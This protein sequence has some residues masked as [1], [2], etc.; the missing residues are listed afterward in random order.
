M[1]IS[2]TELLSYLDMQTQKRG[3]NDYFKEVRA[4]WKWQRNRQM[5]LM[6]II[7]STVYTGDFG[8]RRGNWKL[9]MFF[10]FFFFGKVSQ[11][12]KC[13]RLLLWTFMIGRE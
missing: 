2:F 12:T 10:F 1:A 13:P 8:K 3:S 5:H 4:L 11:R 6:S 7:V 9:H